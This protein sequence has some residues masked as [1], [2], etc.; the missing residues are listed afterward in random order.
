LTD[1]NTGATVALSIIVCEATKAVNMVDLKQ[2]YQLL[3]PE[4][5]PEFQVRAPGRVN[6][7]GE[8]TDYNGGLVLPIAMSQALYVIAGK[9][10]GSD[11][12]VHSTAMDETISFSADHPGTPGKPAWANYIRGVAALLIQ[13][14]IQLKPGNLLI[15]SEVPIGGGV[16]SSAALEVG[17]ALA[18]LSLAEKTMEPVALALLAKQAEHEY[19]QSP[20]GIMDQFICTLGQAGNALLLDCQSQSYEHLPLDLNESVLMI[21]DTQVKHSIGASEYPVRQQQCRKGL[22]TIQQQYP[23]VRSL[24]EV[25]PD[26]LIAC[27]NQMDKTTY[28][29]CRHVQTE[30]SRT[31]EAADALRSGDLQGFGELMYASHHSLRDDYGVSCEELDCLVEIA[32][33]VPGVYGAR[34]TGGGFGGCA[35]ALVRRDSTEELRS[36]VRQKYDSGFDKPAIV[37]TTT[38]SNGAA[39]RKL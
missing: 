33:Q 39:A 13:E 21:M 28:R 38:A 1:K 2:Q 32:G 5:I 14:G 10:K 37:Y 4:A 8:H 15:H 7:I 26:R 35:I 19:A 25:T 22:A 6:L 9:R 30:I 34:M 36:A 18:L 24:R 31:L 29:R 20:C 23:E 27:A 16:S 11:I 12:V 17:T 3:F